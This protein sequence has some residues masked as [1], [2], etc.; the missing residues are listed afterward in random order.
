MIKN[1]DQRTICCKFLEMNI[2]PNSESALYTSFTMNVS[3]KFKN[4]I[5][6]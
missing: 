4:R 5:V 2:I 3:F 6:S 1:G